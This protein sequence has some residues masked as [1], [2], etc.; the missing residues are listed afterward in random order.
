[1]DECPGQVTPGRFIITETLWATWFE[2][3]PAPWCHP[4][5]FT[6]SFVVL[7][8]YFPFSTA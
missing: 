5:I 8:R 6:P 1:M 7:S 3:S 4:R 2:G